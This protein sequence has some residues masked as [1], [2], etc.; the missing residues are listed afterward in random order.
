MKVFFWHANKHQN[1]LQAYFNTLSVK[2][3]Y[4]LILSLLM[5]MIMDSQSTQI[6][7]FAMSLQYLKA[8]IV[9]TEVLDMSKS[10]Q[11]G[12]WKYFCNILRKKCCNFFCVLFCCEAFR[13][14]KRIQSCF[15]FVTHIL[16]V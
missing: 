6:N 14:L 4:K 5:S 16:L 10:S 2:V 9:L 12:I 15:Y 13:Y 11:I 7:K 8:G 1:F 3:S